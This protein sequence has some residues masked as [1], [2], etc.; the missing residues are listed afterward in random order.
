MKNISKQLLLALLTL[1]LAFGLFAIMPVAAGLADEEP[2]DPFTDVSATDWFYDAVIYVY[3]NEIMQG[4]YNEGEEPK[5]APAENFIRAQAAMI[6][7][8]LAGEPDVSE[9]ENSFSDVVEGAWYVD[10][11][12]WAE[13]DGIFQGYGN[14]KFGPNDPL[15]REQLATVVG[16]WISEPK[17]AEEPEEAEEAM[18]AEEPEEPE[19]PEVTGEVEEAEEPEVTEGLEWPDSASISSWAQEHVITLTEMGAFK[20]M[21]GEKFRPKDK[22]IRADIASVLYNVLSGVE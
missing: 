6:F 5:F 18:E 8:R 13:D 22:A 15:T 20:D 7:Y 21:P 2:E 1:A 9:F 17:E 11:I 14:G 12:K 4:S 10:A 16:R 19:E 3:D